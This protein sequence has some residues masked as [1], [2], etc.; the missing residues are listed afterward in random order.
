[1]RSPFSTALLIAAEAPN[2]AI[3]LVKTTIFIISLTLLNPS[4]AIAQSNTTRLS[5]T[6]Q[7]DFPLW[8]ATQPINPAI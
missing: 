1:M 4:T 8:I 3:T 5:V 6:N 7:C 2:N